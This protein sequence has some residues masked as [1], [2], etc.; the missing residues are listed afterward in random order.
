MDNS[1]CCS[2]LGRSK[3]MDLNIEK[4][5]SEKISNLRY[6]GEIDE[7]IKVCLEATKNFQQNNFFYKLLG[8]LYAQKN[9]YVDA[10]NAY[11]EQLKR[12]GTKPD[13]F[14]TFARFYK[15]LTTKVTPEFLIDYQ[16]RISQAIQNGEIPK[17]IH[18]C[19][20]ESFGA[21]FIFDKEILEFFHKSDDDQFFDEVRQFVSSTRDNSIVR[22][23]VLY[24]SGRTKVT[25]NTKTKMFLLS[26]AEKKKLYPEALQLIGKMIYKSKK[27]NP[28]II[29]TL[30]RISRKQGD[31][32]YA[33]NVLNFNNEL[34]EKSDF[35]V[36]YE[37]VYYFDTTNNDE[38]LDKTLEEMLHKAQSS[39]PIA[40]TLYNFYLTF[41]KFDEAQAVSELIQKLTSE[42][43]TKSRKIKSSQKQREEQQ[44]E[45]EQIVW[46]KLKDLVSEQEH[47]RQMIALRD[48][49]KGFSHELG[50]PITNIRYSV[51]LQEMKIQRGLSSTN[52]IKRLFTT[53]LEQ[54][55]RI[56]TLLER[57]RP[58]VSS[59]SQ[60]ALFSVN[61][62]ISQVFDD[63]DDRLRDNLI[64]YNITAENELILFGDRIQFS[65]VFYNLILN[66]IQ[67]INSN[68]TI[69]VELS[70][71]SDEIIILF[72]DDGPGIPAEHEK[73]IFEPFFSTKDPTSGNGGEGLGLFVVWNIL[74]MYGGTIQVNLKYKNGAQFIIKIPAYKEE[75][76]SE[77]HTNH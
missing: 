46:Q 17:N 76:D 26:V 60:S 7:A 68:G 42:Q 53:I 41:N 33:E 5:Y 64:T 19:L 36:L 73:K 49:I 39:I 16:N 69:E 70:Q 51:Q 14:K 1:Y 57:F 43:K 2:I 8:D 54:T 35:N 20:I 44:L 12:L 72:S 22:A 56:G 65:Q 77:S 3:S 34:I 38:L 74:R 48:L 59:K 66:S 58:I 31:Y 4:Q 29:R 52:D 40:R 13:Q 6:N 15:T 71:T 18:S 27:F 62:C 37:L 75:K 47:N 21:P 24:Q 10:A 32:N 50:Q 11:F 23:L 25:R 55:A 67:A 63:L 61:N 30:L 45:S 28:L 9:N